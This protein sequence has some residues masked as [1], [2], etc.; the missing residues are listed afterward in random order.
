[1]P[2]FPQVAD[3]APTVAPRQN[4]RKFRS[5]SLFLIVS[6]LIS[7]STEPSFFVAALCS[8]FVL[9]AHALGSKSHILVT[10]SLLHAH[11]LCF[12]LGRAWQK[13]PNFV[14]SWSI[15][16]ELPCSSFVFSAW[17]AVNKNPDKHEAESKKHGAQSMSTK[18]KAR[19]MSTKQRQKNWAL[20]R[21]RLIWK[22]SPV[23]L[24]NSEKF[25]ILLNLGA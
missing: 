9:R 25:R 2:H 10:N 20:L 15:G 18:H 14:E 8:C 22:Y 3:L 4:I 7:A 23:V 24:E 11:A 17:R 5:H 12:L 1:M 16:E 21:L 13:D 6:L 19:S